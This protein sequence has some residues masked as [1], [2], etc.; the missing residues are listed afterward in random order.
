MNAFL[1]PLCSDPVEPSGA[2]DADDNEVAAGWCD[3]CGE[4]VVADEEEAA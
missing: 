2:L 4:Y 3:R 1:C